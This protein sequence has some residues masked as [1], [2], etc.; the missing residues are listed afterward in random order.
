MIEGILGKNL[1]RV[2]EKWISGIA[3]LVRPAPSGALVV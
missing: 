2:S 3:L 1:D